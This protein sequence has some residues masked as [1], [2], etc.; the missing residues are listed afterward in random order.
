MEACPS[1]AMSAVI[2]MSAENLEKCC[3]QA[4]S[5]TDGG[6]VIIANFNT[7]EQLVISGSPVSVTAAGDIAKAQ[8]AKVIPLPVGG[9]FHSPLMSQAAVE[10]AGELAQIQLADA[11]FPV[12]QNYDALPGTRASE[13]SSKLAQ[14]MSSA[15]RWYNT[16]EYMLAQGVDTFIEIGPGKALSGMLKK[17]QRSATALN[18]YDAET[19]EQTLAQLKETASV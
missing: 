12:V 8:G 10:F 2:S 6:V 18:I 14:Q 15:V 13:L 4:R 11:N 1:G 9:A 17:I 7:R 3:E 5:Q 19:L 16:I